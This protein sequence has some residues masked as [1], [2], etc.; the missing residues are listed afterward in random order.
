MFPINFSVYLYVMNVN[1][2]INE[3]NDFDWVKNIPAIPEPKEGEVF[4]IVD[5]DSA[6]D[7]VSNNARI[8][9]II[10]MGKTYNGL[11]V[12]G[13]KTKMVEMY[14]ALRLGELEDYH[15]GDSLDIT[16]VLSTIQWVLDDDDVEYSKA[17]ELITGRYWRPWSERGTPGLPS[18]RGVNE[19][20]DFDWVEDIPVSRSGGEVYVGSKWTHYLD[21]PD[22]H[23]ILYTIDN[24]NPNNK[25]IRIS[26][27]DT[28]S[29]VVPLNYFDV[30]KDD[31]NF[32]NGRVDGIVESEFSWI[33]DIKP[34]DLSSCTWVIETTNG[35]EWAEVEKFLFNNGWVWDDSEE[36]EQTN[37]DYEERYH[38]FFPRDD[39]SDMRFDAADE[40]HFYNHGG[41]LIYHF[42]DYRFIKWSNIKGGVLNES[43]FDWAEETPI[44]PVHVGGK[45]QTPNGN[46]LTITKI[47][48]KRKKNGMGTVRMV[49]WEVYDRY[50][51]KWGKSS[52]RYWDVEKRVEDGIWN[53]V[54]DDTINESSEF[55]WTD[56]V[57]VG[58][59]IDRLMTGPEMSDY[60]KERLQGYGKFKVELVSFDGND[61][62]YTTPVIYI[63]TSSGYEITIWDTE[64]EG[65]YD[66][67]TFKG[68]EKLPV[69][70]LVN[71]V[72]NVCFTS[73]GNHGSRMTREV[74]DEYC[75]LYN[76][77]V[78]G[79]INES[80]FDWTDE[81][82]TWDETL[83]NNLFVGSKFTHE[84]DGEPDGHG[85]L[86]TI[87]SIGE[88]GISF[89]YS[90]PGDFYGRESIDITSLDDMESMFYN[91]QKIKFHNDPSTYKSIQESDFEWVKEHKVTYDVSEMEVG[92]TYQF[93]PDLTL[94]DN[95]DV[96]EAPS[97]VEGYSES[98]FYIIKQEPNSNYP[99]QSYITFKP[100]GKADRMV[101]DGKYTR[102]SY[103]ARVFQWGRFKE[104]ENPQM[105]TRITESAFDWA[106][107]TPVPPIHVGGKLRIP[108]GNILTIDK[109]VDNSESEGYGEYWAVKMVHWKIFHDGS[110]NVGSD[111]YPDV[112]ERIE[113]G[114]WNPVSDETINE[115][116]F[117]WVKNISPFEPYIGMKWKTKVGGNWSEDVYEIINIKSG[118]MGLKWYNHRGG[119]TYMDDYS[120]D[121]YWFLVNEDRVEIMNNLNES[122]F[123]WADESGIGRPVGNWDGYNFSGPKSGQI[124]IY[125]DSDGNTH[126]LKVGSV[127]YKHR[128]RKHGGGYF[129][130][131]GE[132]GFY[133]SSITQDEIDL[134]NQSWENPDPREGKTEINMSRQEYNDF[135]NQGR[136]TLSPMNESNDFEWSEEIPAKTDVRHMVGQ[137]FNVWEPRTG[138]KIVEPEVVGGIYWIEEADDSPEG[139]HACWD[140]RIGDDVNKVCTRYR[141]DTFN[142]FFDNGHFRIV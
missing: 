49:H 15:D 130:T 69:S 30:E 26:W 84:D 36:G 111:R 45:L 24:I 21:G 108:N 83:R 119:V 139:Y 105:E 81:V 82:P 116:E 94:L 90:D 22:G 134:H 34:F 106:E 37:S 27:G 141:V 99:S 14:E 5:N 79:T 103:H 115:S 59:D 51:G 38:H 142:G 102:L 120:L 7:K 72:K 85:I 86:Y 32:H 2:T 4:Y 88:D 48:H 109:I 117:D 62:I 140:E 76:A 131:D 47:N 129:G 123:D 104:I 6:G 60:L 8:R 9:F 61:D 17:V 58:L 13:D 92:K 118:V 55:D 67:I 138:D 100:I 77:L 122:E 28:E 125:T 110:W 57:P 91:G 137:K 114:T 35:D 124:Y 132:V 63:P 101:Y 80:E 133:D 3:S 128:T 42:K 10:K 40:E 136:L 75:Q 39:C 98:K 95:P 25:T 71:K 29:D 65:S 78:S 93:V 44:P 31:I 74:T 1:K 96:D 66:E 20:N 73:R 127:Y 23:G 68:D 70:K 54:P 56:S 126:S 19:S 135:I 12:D 11:N 52:D 33:K 64:D 87:T 16:S 107:E 46:I 53:P 41:E 50:V 43:D 113:D 18:V 97:W 112:E 121:S 89:G